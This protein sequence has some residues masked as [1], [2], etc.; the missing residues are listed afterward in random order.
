MKK[1]SIIF[2]SVLFALKGCHPAFAYEDIITKLNNYVSIEVDTSLC[3]TNTNF[4]WLLQTG[5]E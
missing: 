1:I 4:R 2:A 3:K 5:Y